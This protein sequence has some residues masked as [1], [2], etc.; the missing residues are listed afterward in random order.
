MAFTRSRVQVPPAPPKFFDFK[1]TC[2]TQ[3]SPRGTFGALPPRVLI[4]KSFPLQL[5]RNKVLS[6]DSAPD[7]RR[8]FGMGSEGPEVDDV[9]NFGNAFLYQRTDCFCLEFSIALGRS[10]VF[11]SEGSGHGFIG[12]A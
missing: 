3:K 6:E 10:E 4:F 5:V 1:W 8:L 11:V 7:F 12:V 9:Y 2:N